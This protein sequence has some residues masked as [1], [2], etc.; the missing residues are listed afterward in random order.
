MRRP[1]A[2]CLIFILSMSLVGFAD[3]RIQRINLPV[4]WQ[5]TRSLILDGSSTTVTE[6]FRET[7]VLEISPSGLVNLVSPRASVPA[8]ALESPTSQR[9]SPRWLGMKEADLGYLVGID[10]LALQ[11]NDNYET[12]RVFD[13]LV[14]IQIGRSDRYS[15]GINLNWSE[16]QH[17]VVHIDIG[18]HVAL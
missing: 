4:A 6:S 18:T 2:T 17:F 5:I 7:W 16:D 10:S 1:L 15:S 11:D 13:R 12:L 9:S 3:A 8:Y 14:F